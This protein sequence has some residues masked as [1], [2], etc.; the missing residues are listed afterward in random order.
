MGSLTVRNIGEDV[1]KRL[2]LRAAANGR[3]MEEEVRLLLAEGAAEARDRRQAERR[4][5]QQRRPAPRR[6][7]ASILLVIAG[8]IAAY[9]SL[10][11]IRR[12]RERGFAR[13]RGDDQ[14]GAGV[15]DA[16][17]GRRDRGRACLHRPVRSGIRI[18]RRPHPAGARHRSRR[19]RARDRRPDGQDGERPCRRSRDRRAARHRQDRSCSRPP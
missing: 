1:K 6:Q 15:R 13:A 17:V 4:Q 14:G 5:A 7:R 10:D 8:G 2:R 3:S 16:A 9:K 12:L 19:G 11:L 18:R